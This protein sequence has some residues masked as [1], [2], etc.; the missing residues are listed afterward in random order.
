MGGQSKND[1]DK[2]YWRWRWDSP[3]IV[4]VIQALYTSQKA[5]VKVEGELTKWFSVNGGV[6]QGC[7]LSPALFNNYSEMHKAMESSSHMEP[8]LVD[9]GLCIS[10]HKR[11]EQPA[12]H[13]SENKC[14]NG[15]NFDHVQNFTYHGASFNRTLDGS[16]RYIK[17]CQFPDPS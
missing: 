4:A 15:K 7:I 3:V 6:R 1:R 9:G 2:D 16:K 12:R 17:G 5:A 11:Y 13:T 10:N 14:R 8:T